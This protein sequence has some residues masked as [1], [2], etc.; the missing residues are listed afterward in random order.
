MTY[1]SRIIVLL[2]VGLFMMSAPASADDR[3]TVSGNIDTRFWMSS[4]YSRWDHNFTNMPLSGAAIMGQ[5]ADA[6]DLTFAMTRFNLRFTIEA[7]ENSRAVLQ[8]HSDKEWGQSGVL[9]GEGEYTHGASIGAYGGAAAIE[10]YWFEGLIP[11]T[12]AK[13]EIGVPY[14]A[15]ESGAFG[16]ATK[17]FN[18]AAPGLTLSAPLSDTISTYTWYA[19]LGQDYDGFNAGGNGDDFALGT[20]ATMTLAEGLSVD[21]IYAYHFA[22]CGTGAAAPCNVAAGGVSW[23]SEENRHWIGSTLRYQY[24]DFSFLPSLMLY[25]ADDDMLGDSE[26]FVL[27]VRGSYTTGPLSLSGRIVYTPGSTF[28]SDGSVNSDRDYDVI[29]VWAIPGAVEGFALF[30]NAYG[31]DDLGPLPFGNTIQTNIRHDRFGLMHAAAMVN[32]TLTPQTSLAVNLGIFNSAEDT[33]GIPGT[34]ALQTQGVTYAGGSHVATEFDAIL[35]YQLYSNA[36]V[37]FW[38]AY[39]MTGD[40]LDLRAADGTTY[41]SQDV[42]GGGARVVYSF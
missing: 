25:I 28:N 32:Y 26:S 11:G 24:G 17:L 40:A 9:F 35:T 38:A 15:A 19:W 5:A 18:T 6:E 7:F 36:S 1:V 39:A 30:G 20:R 4:N 10:G 12:A 41:E 13:F 21:L 3:L 34:V 22:E 2:L 37:L 27:D 14:F 23:A 29:G 31:R 16:E 8:T 33:T 42:V